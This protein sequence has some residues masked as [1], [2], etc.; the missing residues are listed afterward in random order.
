MERI[1]FFIFRIT[2]FLFLESNKMCYFI[3]YLMFYI[4]SFRVGLF[5]WQNFTLWVGNYV[6]TINSTTF[7]N[8][9]YEQTTKELKK[10][11]PHFN[12]FK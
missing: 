1:S 11:Q 3:E 12:S 7:G 9:K 10:Q 4:T 2:H 5:D 8:K 6:S